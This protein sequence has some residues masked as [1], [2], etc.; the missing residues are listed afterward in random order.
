MRASSCPTCSS[1]LIDRLKASQPE[2][3]DPEKPCTLPVP[4]TD[5]L[6]QTPFCSHEPLCAD[7]QPSWA[8]GARDT[9]LLPA[10]ATLI[11]QLPRR[12]ASSMLRLTSLPR[13]PP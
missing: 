6:P 7:D 12:S 3:V 2:K 13:H 10:M 4:P 11:I 9:T 5:W 8:R 1:W